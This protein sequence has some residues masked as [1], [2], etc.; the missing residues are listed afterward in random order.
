MQAHLTQVKPNWEWEPTLLRVSDKGV[1]AYTGLA[2]RVQFLRHMGPRK[3]LLI[4][5]LVAEETGQS[6]HDAQRRGFLKKAAVALGGVAAVLSMPSGVGHA[7]P[8]EDLPEGAELWEGFLLLPEGV[9]VS[10]FVIPVPVPASCGAGNVSH[11]N[12][13]RGN[14]ESF[15]DLLTLR[16][17]ANYPIYAAQY[18]PQDIIFNRVEIFS[19]A[20]SGNVYTTSLIYCAPDDLEVENIYL[21]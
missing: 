17:R 2:M 1:Q 14:S 3:A 21:R 11:G 7:A 5:R 8:S 18:L 12:E 15:S 16:N 4:A 6:A 13:T 19:F 9:P 20:A 10:R